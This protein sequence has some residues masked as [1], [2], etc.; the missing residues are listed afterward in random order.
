MH[1]LG[2]DFVIFDGVNQHISLSTQQIQQL[3][4]RHFG[5]GC[6]QI[7]L[8]EPTTTS[9][10]DFN[11]RIFNADGHEVNQCGNGARCLAR[12]IRD[13]V[14]SDKHQIAVNTRN[15]RLILQ[16]DN[17]DAI[18][19]NMGVPKHRPMEIPIAA[20]RESTVYTITLT[21]RDY[22]FGAVSMG[23]PH[24][25]IEVAQIETAPIDSIGPLIENNALFPER[26]NVGFMQII[27]RHHIRLRVYERGA[28]ETLACGS[29][30]C[31][32]MVI[33]REHN[34]LDDPVQVDLAG[35]QLMISW[36]GRGLP[37]YMTGP[38]ESVY[39]GMI[40]I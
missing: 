18:T 25:V 3:A 20:D 36:K 19:V 10:T 30:T 40:Q 35:G 2:N 13:K 31:A 32:A 26:V 21:G 1:G 14:L 22:Q 11:Y 15:G 28:G 6:D 38:A 4:D 16:F 7:L 8:I 29:G 27:N 34:K 17:E 5:I 37:V 39:E 23:N 12:F 24:A 33:G 9:G